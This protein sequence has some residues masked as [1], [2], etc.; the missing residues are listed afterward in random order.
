MPVEDLDQSTYPADEMAAGNPETVADNIARLWK[1][2]DERLKYE[3]RDNELRTQMLI[4]SQTME[5]AQAQLDEK[6]KEH[7]RKMEIEGRLAIER[8]KANHAKQGAELDADPFNTE[9]GGT[10]LIEDPISQVLDTI[11]TP[12]EDTL[13]Q[14]YMQAMN[15]K[16]DRTAAEL[17]TMHKTTATEK[18]RLQKFIEDVPKFNGEAKKAHA[19]CAKIQLYFER[20]E[21]QTVPAATVKNAIWEAL[22]DVCKSRTQHL[23]P[24]SYAWKSYT[25][26]VY[27]EKILY[28][29]ITQ[30]SAEGAKALFEK[31]TQGIK[32]D[33]IS[34]YDD[35]LSLYLQG[36]PAKIRDILQFK[37]HA[38]D[39]IYN[40]ELRAK[41]QEELFDVPTNE[42]K[43][44]S[45]IITKL[46]FLRAF[47]QKKE[48]NMMGLKDI[49]IKP[50]VL[51]YERSGQL[52]MEVNYVPARSDFQ[53][54]EEEDDMLDGGR[55][56][57]AVTDTRECFFCKRTGHLKA[58][59]RAFSK[60]KTQNP[61]KVS[62]MNGGNGRNT[63]R[64]NFTCF[65]CNKE[66]HR[67]RDCKAPSTGRSTV[68]CY[69][70][71]KEGHISRDCRAPRR[72]GAKPEGQV[73]H[74][75]QAVMES[76]RDQFQKMMEDV[77][78]NAKAG[79]FQE[80]V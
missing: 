10:F 14:M 18:I 24:N 61:S 59:C 13:G 9:R 26:D 42:E 73:N 4:Q 54:A 55:E 50:E 53:T 44:R 46:Q 5:M 21:I 78:D 76:M 30:Q 66:G 3:E 16:E 37:R 23:V 67:A 70:C 41:V 79:V 29:F 47:I 38:I 40:D 32:E 60:W 75:G 51:N 22:S 80:R 68:S 36:F 15:A 8:T 56:I 19:W 48:G 27:F 52:P 62:V 28:S 7:N 45:T 39:G 49:F 43:I 74:L 1:A 20:K 33:V 57:N 72:N 12:K 65:N 63:G 25:T 71:D 31:R 2:M 35:K 77:L 58:D 34:Y 11:R 6:I 69:N 64:P 17:L